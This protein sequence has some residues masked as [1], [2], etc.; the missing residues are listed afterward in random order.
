MAGRI[1]PLPALKDCSATVAAGGAADFW[2][3]PGTGVT[4][5]CL[6]IVPGWKPLQP[7]HCI[8]PS[9]NTA[10]PKDDARPERG[11][12]IAAW[13]KPPIFL[14]SVIELISATA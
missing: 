1:R 5:S 13:V 3:E 8:V 7:D 10:L 14:R 4:H 9:R 12:S 11:A 6:H 2:A